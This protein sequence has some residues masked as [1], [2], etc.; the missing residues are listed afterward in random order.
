MTGGNI[1]STNQYVSQPH[2]AGH[3]EPEFASKA[4]LS[5][6][7]QAMIEPQSQILRQ[8]LKVTNFQM[9]ADTLG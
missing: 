1:F 6:H 3:Q 7:D 9:E 8:S 2:L 5:I 4:S